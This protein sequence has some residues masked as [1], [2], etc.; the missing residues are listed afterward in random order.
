MKKD[1]NRLVKTLDEDELREELRMLYD[2]FP[3]L[4]EYY[5]LE[6]GAS[7]KSILDKY[8]KD[9]RKAFF[10]A[11]RNVSRRS[12]SESKKVI[13]AFAAISIHDRD[14]LELTFYRAE[15]M[16]DAIVHYNVTNESFISSTVKAY[17]EAL[18]FAEKELLLEIYQ[19]QI[20]ALAEYFE[21]NVRYG[22][23][24]FWPAYGRYF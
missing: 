23:Y 11:R 22:S 2:R 21:A 13:K 19:P 5:K 6:L 8:K 14:L 12:R 1:F 7:T 4:R 9:L 10:S 24:S 17:E 3:V 16:V 20:K 18:A 15:V